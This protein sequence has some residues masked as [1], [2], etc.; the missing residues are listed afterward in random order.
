MP[1]PRFHRLDPAKRE[2]IL[3][4]AIAEFAHQGFDGA[5]LA[6]IIADA[7]ISKGALYYWFDDK[8][9]LFTAA[10]VAALRPVGLAIG[11]P[12]PVGNIDGFWSAVTG[13]IARAWSSLRENERGLMML[14]TAIRAHTAGELGDAWRDFT[15]PATEAATEIVLLG[16]AV[17]AVREDLPIDLLIAIVV[18][19]AEAADQFFEERVADMDNEEVDAC[20]EALHDVVRRI[21]SPS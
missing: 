17:G 20:I 12:G 21:A 13:M 14:R 3:D 11:K 10:A 4:A 6:R 19:V 5:S 15:G 8:E 2:L 16:Q 9:D 18:G 1:R 7:Q